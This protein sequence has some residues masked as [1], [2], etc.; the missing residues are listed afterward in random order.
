[1]PLIVGFSKFTVD[2]SPLSDT[3]ILS[4]WHCF[5]DQ[6]YHILC[7]IQMTVICAEIFWIMMTLLEGLF[8][9]VLNIS[10]SVNNKYEFN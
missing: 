7:K 5:S 1:L 4:V 10:K 9:L 6:L 8:Q 2:L 3:F